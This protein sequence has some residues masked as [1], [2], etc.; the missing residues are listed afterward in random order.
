M[1]SSHLKVIWIFLIREIF[2]AEWGILGFEIR[3]VA[4][5]IRNPAVP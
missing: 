2:I 5:G 3:N 1:G 4:Q